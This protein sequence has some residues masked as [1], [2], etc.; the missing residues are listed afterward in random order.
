MRHASGCQ[1]IGHHAHHLVYRSHCPSFT[2]FT[3]L[4]NGAW[5][6]LACHDLAH[7]THNGN[8]HPLR[9]RVAVD[10]INAEIL[11]VMPHKFKDLKVK[12]FKEAA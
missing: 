10:D 1:F 11:R 7:K 9:L 5:V 12:H 6:S 4:T 8:I 3:V 2:H